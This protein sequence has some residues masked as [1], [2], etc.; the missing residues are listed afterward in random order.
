MGMKTILAILLALSACGDDIATTPDAGQPND[1]I[2][3]RRDAGVQL[4]SG[5]GGCMGNLPNSRTLTINTGDPIP[6]EIINELQDM[7]IGG[8]RK[9]FTRTWWPV[10]VDGAALSANISYLQANPAS[11]T[12]SA[13][14]KTTGIFSGIA[15]ICFDSGDILSR[16]DVEIYGDGSVDASLSVVYAPNM[17]TVAGVLSAFTPANNVP[18]S[19]GV[20]FNTFPAQP[21]VDG[22]VARVIIAANAANLYFGP[23][24][25]TF[26]R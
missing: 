20:L 12:F 16:V 1:W 21:L 8:N 25:A 23:L 15:P 24:R 26:I 18:A 19:W 17:H 10:F 13:V 14:N 2:G 5:A 3:P 6:P 4:P 22:A 9:L 7:S 11:G